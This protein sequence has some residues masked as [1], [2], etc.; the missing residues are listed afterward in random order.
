MNG[1]AKSMLRIV[2]LALVACL[3]GASCKTMTNAQ[4][5]SKIAKKRYKYIKHDCNCHSFLYQVEDAT[6]VEG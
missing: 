6:N 3:I 4:R 2:A 1:M 5:A